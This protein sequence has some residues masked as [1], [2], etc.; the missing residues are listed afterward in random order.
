MVNKALINKGIGLLLI[1]STILLSC[2]KGEDSGEDQYYIR[3]KADLT[4]IVFTDQP[5]LT[6][7]CSK[8]GDQH[9]CTFRG[10]DLTS[11][12]TITVFDDNTISNGTYS[13]FRTEGGLNFGTLI[14]YEDDSGTIFE[15]RNGVT[16][17]TVTITEST[18]TSIRGVFTGKVATMG[19]TMTI[20]EGEFFV[21]RIN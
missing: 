17:T 10:G 1:F 3:F 14:S 18:A 19:T 13:D 6:T 12:I 4:S 15:Q 20:S 7:V 5:V 11:R 2:S 8:T 21:K 16:G 9:E